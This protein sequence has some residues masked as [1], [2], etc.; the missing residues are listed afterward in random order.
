M[1]KK[2]KGIRQDFSKAV[3]KGSRSG[4]GK[5]VYEHWDTLISIWGGSPS[6]QSLQFGVES[7]DFSVL[8]NLESMDNINLTDSDSDL[9]PESHC[10]PVNPSSSELSEPH[11]NSSNVS[12]ITCGTGS[13]ESTSSGRSGKR[14]TSPCPALIDQ[15]RKHLEK[16]LS[17]AQRDRVL[18]ETTKEE[19]VMRREMLQAFTESSK[20]SESAMNEIANSMNNFSQG[21]LQV[22]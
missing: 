4:S 1:R 15:K 22:F 12:E 17:A 8:A 11:A 2:I 9:V 21:L 7:H 13:E 20:R 3:V 5:I 18:L 10:S 19:A 14:K 6:T 16:K